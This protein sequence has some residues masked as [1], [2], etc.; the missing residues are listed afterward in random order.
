YGFFAERE[1]SGGPEIHVDPNLQTIRPFVAGFLARGAPLSDAGL[2]SLIQSQEK[3]AE[4]FGR[5]RRAVAIGAY[6]AAQIQF[7]IAYRAGDPARDRY[8]PLGHA[9][10][11]PLAQVLTEHPKGQEYG[12]LLKGFARYPLLVDAAGE[13]LSMPPIVNSQGLGA[14]VA[15]DRELFVEVT[16]P[17]LRALLLALNIAAVD[18]ADRGWT[19]EPVTVVYPYD[20]PFGRRVRTP[21]DFSSP[22]SIGRDLVGQLLG[23]SLSDA[24]ITAGLER[25]GYRAIAVPAGAPITVTPP[26]YRDDLLHPV[27]VIEDV[28]IAHGYDRF[29]PILPAEFTVGRLSREQLL[30]R[31]LTELM[32]GAG[33]QEAISNI[34]TARELVVDRMGR[35]DG[36]ANLVE[37]ENVMSAN[38]AVL[39]DAI[40]PSLLAVEAV[41]SKALYPHRIFEVG[42]CATRDS[43]RNLGSRTLLLL[44]ALVAHAEATFSEQHGVLDTLLYYLGL[45]YTLEPIEHPSCLPGRAGRIRIAGHDAGWIGELAPSCLERW[46]MGVPASAFELDLAMLL[47]AGTV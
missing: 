37:I 33:Y 18:L 45:D 42:E 3:L 31:R 32:L 7:P 21:H 28:A 27:D 40:V 34:L 22:V 46:G 5:K 29:T 14:V 26:A 41:S 6:R 1:V 24:E 38:F 11:I 20:T 4:N 25:S 2:K 19:I 35:T 9:A 13:V 23:E 12:H 43:S 15:G 44:G 36:G 8:V 39:R 17:D 16:G 30:A 47:A 10:A